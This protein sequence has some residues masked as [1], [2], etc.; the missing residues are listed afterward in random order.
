M[1]VLR[2]AGMKIPPEQAFNELRRRVALTPRELSLN[3]SGEPR[4]ETAVKFRVGDAATL[5]WASKIGGWSI[6]DAGIDALE[7]Y[8]DADELYA[9]L[10]RRYREIDQRRKQAIQNLSDVHQFIATT[11]QMVEPGSWTA[12]DDLAELADTSADEVA[13]FLASG[14]VRIADSYRVLNADGTIPA[15]GMLN[16]AYRGVDLQHRLADEGIEFDSLGRASQSQRLRADALK[17]LLEARADEEPSATARRAWMV[18]G[19]NVDGVNLVDDWIRDRFVSLS[20]SQLT[21]V[22]PG[23]RVRRVEAGGGGRVPA[24]VVCVPRAA[25]RGVR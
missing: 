3:D 21:G 5:R 10:R 14:T 13:D 24:Q 6:T 15:E 8:H 2:D 19:S 20:A 9:E 17:E 1:E 7:T 11:L 16:S 4:Y 18:R 23:C 25:A 22:D 12:H